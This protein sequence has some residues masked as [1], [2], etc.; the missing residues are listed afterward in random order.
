[1]AYSIDG[2]ATNGV[3]YSSLSGSYTFS[4]GQSSYA[5]PI[6]VIDDSLVEGSETVTITITADPANYN[7][8]TP[9]QTA[10]IA[11]NDSYSIWIVSPNGNQYGS[12]AG[13][14]AAVVLQRSTTIGTVT[15]PVNY[16]NI[17]AVANQDYLPSPSSVTFASGSNT[18]TL[19]VSAIDDSVYDPGETLSASFG[20]PDTYQFTSTN[21]QT[22]G[23]IDN[24]VRVSISSGPT[25]AEPS[26]NSY[27]ALTRETEDLASLGSWSVP[28]MVDS[29]AGQATPNADYTQLPTSV[30]FAAGSTTATVSVSVIDDFLVEPNESVTL[31]LGTLPSSIPGS[32]GKV[33]AGA[34]YGI[35]TITSDDI[36]PSVSV[37][38]TTDGY[39]RGTQSGWVT[40]NRSHSKGSL[41][42][43]Y[44]L[45]LNGGISN[46]VDFQNVP[47]AG[48][49]TF[50]D[51]T[52]TAKLE[53]RPLNDAIYDPNESVTVTLQPDSSGQQ[54]L[55]GSPT[56]GT[57]R[58]L[59]DEAKV[60]IS[61]E[62]DAAEPS[63]EGQFRFDRVTEDVG[64]SL[65]V[66][67]TLGAGTAT[68]GTDFQTLSRT[69]MF[70]AN[71]TY[72]SLP[73]V[74]IDDYRVENSN[75]TVIVQLATGSNYILNTSAATATVTIIDDD[76]YPVLTISG[77]QDA[78]ESGQ[79]G[80]VEMSR[81]AS[82]KGPSNLYFTATNETSTSADYT[83][84][85]SNGILSFS[86]GQSKA[87]IFITATNDTIYDPNKSMKVTLVPD[88]VWYVLGSP[89]TQSVK[90]IDDE[91]K[92]GISTVTDAAEP[93]TSGLFRFDR[94]SEDP[95]GSLTVNLTLGA[96]TA[97]EGIDYQ[98]LSRTVSFSPNST[99][100]TL[101]V[102]VID[103]YRVENPDE[104][105][106]VQIA[107]GSGYIVHSA[108]AAAT[109]TIIDDDV[110]PILTITGYQDAKESGQVGWV[111]VT[112]TASTK[113]PTSLFF[114]ASNITA[115]NSDYTVSPSNGILSFSDGQSSAKIFITATN[116]A[117]YD[118]N[119]SMKI[120]LLP[121]SVWYQL[122][123]PTSQSIRVIDD[124][125]KVSILRESDATE[126]STNGKFRFDRITEDDSRSIIV[127]VTVQPAPGLRARITTHSHLPSRS[128]R[129]VR[130]RMPMYS[131]R[132]IRSQN[133]RKPSS[134]A[135][136]TGPG[137]S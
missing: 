89:N 127:P 69:V 26:T 7:V 62:L 110:Y 101:S 120:T 21:T 94:T 32:T 3:D 5:L 82:T 31:R 23:I 135:S 107:S 67:V 15:V 9:S 73:V 44:S 121:D 131:L 125:S 132:T 75:E 126:P 6:T 111:N 93:S 103:D 19:Y 122:G 108:A 133:G 76:I 124:E 40:L 99:T 95:S 74:V 48:V 65:S 64:G 56:S 52:S 85:P 16:N 90:L 66:N 83:V 116:D 50:A 17:T 20:T 100:A 104:T 96:G 119:K 58:I 11:D 88:S 129:A 84:S 42:V 12:E 35:V 34:S 81:T 72:A 27:F 33:L 47:S 14:S 60:S 115:T 78:K 117:I 136:P 105:V 45:G 30:S 37:T 137:T 54:Y 134:R 43:A 86:D 70:S 4:S 109:V 28:V 41:S 55:L 18:A 46:G 77:Y 51:G 25:A 68:E 13:K 59:D 38:S 29:G 22:M 57:V 49:I 98:T 91:S 80:W 128:R 113:G 112:R 87:K 2:Q 71:S 123:S 106:I 92:I 130:S 102:N 97:T 24:E 36:F 79:V 118:P 53:I 63:T 8:G 61:K 114:S 1:M 39:E 10:I